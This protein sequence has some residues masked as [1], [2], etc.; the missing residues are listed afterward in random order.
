MSGRL[1]LG[2]VQF[3]LPYGVANV[4]GQVSRDEA[5]AILEYAWEA[6]VDTL[7]T[8]IAYG[9][10]EERLGKIGVAGWQIV[11]KLPAVQHGCADIAGWVE[12]SIYGS[13]RRLR[14][15]KLKGLLLHQPHEL[16]EPNG[17][18]LYQAMVGLKQAGLVE[19]I[20]VSIYGPS[21]LNALWSR[22]EFDLVQAPFNVIDRRLASSGWLER[23]HQAGTEVHVRSVF[24]QGLLV[25]NG[26]QRSTK[27]NRW[28]SR[29]DVWRRW[30]ADRALTP[31]QA[32]LGFTLS[33]PE[34]SRVL[35]G[36]ERV[37][38]LDEILTAIRAGAE[39]T[40]PPDS[41]VSE[42][43]DLINPSRWNVV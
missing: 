30:L 22:F 18:A 33:Y 23:L 24:L 28:Q 17:P 3:G 1:G 39:M 43:L 26:A 2:T 14:V 15:S 31:V 40:M 20:G 16:L 38:Q 10:S 5:T 37:A 32:C 36:V 25:M 8:A 34:V 41:L 42:D 7:D 27:F 11:S 29:W 6:G 21:E 12:K 35:V 19:K 4:D 9:D 13:L